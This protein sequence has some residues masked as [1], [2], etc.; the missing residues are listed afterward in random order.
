[1]DS[2]TAMLF[3]VVPIE[4]RKGVLVVATADPTNINNIDNLQ[5]LLD[6]T[7]KPVLASPEEISHALNK[8]YGLADSSVETM[9]SS[10]TAMSLCQISESATA[11][12]N[13]GVAGLTRFSIA[14]RRLSSMRHWQGK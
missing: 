4:E 12:C 10:S 6:R 14:L 11:K 2:R 1:M 13:G 8:Y 7:V 5:R 9:L 3:R